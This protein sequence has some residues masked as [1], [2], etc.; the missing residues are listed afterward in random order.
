[1]TDNYV[2]ICR[3][4]VDDECFRALSSSGAGGARTARGQPLFVGAASLRPCAWEMRADKP[5][6]SGRRQRSPTRR[7]SSC[8][9]LN[10]FTAL[11][12]EFTFA[13]EAE[14]DHIQRIVRSGSFYELEELELMAR[15]AGAPRRILDVGANIGNHSVYFAHRFDAD[16]VVPVEPNPLVVGLLRE[17]LRLNWRPCM[18][19]RLVGA[20]LSDRPGSGEMIVASTANLGG[21]KLDQ[22]DGGSIPVY[23]G[24]DV[25]PDEAF[26]LIKIDVEGMELHVVAGLAEVLRRSD[27]T[28]FLEVLIGNIDEAI[29]QMRALGYRYRMSHRR[30]GRCLNLIFQRG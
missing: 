16:L 6:R 12:R 8:M 7:A 9:R 5:R 18:D 17:N 27:A 21:A 13:T 1:M 2:V 28:V 10:S 25:F 4:D 22:G 11:G 23:R 26:D 20:G 24:D 3:K 29:E 30:Y 15:V 19:L 14:D